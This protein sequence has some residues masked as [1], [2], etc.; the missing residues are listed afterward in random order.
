MGIFALIV[1][2]FQGGMQTDFKEIKPVLSPAISLATIGVLLT[3]TV[4]G[5]CA[6]YILNISLKEGLLIGAIVGSTDAAAVFSVLGGT[7]L[8]K[9]IRM[10]LEA[11]SGVMTPWPYF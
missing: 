9:R 10:T 1:I 6:T 5:L 2:L 7:N 8:K 3:T 4:V 11:E